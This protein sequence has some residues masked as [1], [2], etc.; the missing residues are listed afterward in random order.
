MKPLELKIAE[1]IVIELFPALL[2]FSG[3]STSKLDYKGENI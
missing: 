3:L 1:L 2:I